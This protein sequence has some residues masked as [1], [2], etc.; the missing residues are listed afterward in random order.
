[1]ITSQSVSHAPSKAGLRPAWLDESIFPFRSRFIEISGTKIHYI[2]EG[3][4]QPL[5]LLHAA[6]AS[7]FIYREFIRRLQSKYRCI[8]LDYP[9]FGL[10]EVENGYRVSI[11]VLSQ[12]VEDF[13][14]RL[15]LQHLTMMV[16]DSSGPIGLGAAA[17]DAERYK[18]FIVTD[19]LGFP[20]DEYPVVRL[21][22]KAATGRIFRWLNRK[23]NLLAVLV[24]SVAPV[25]RR[26]S[27][28]EKRAYRQTFATAE[29]RDR[30]LDLLAELLDQ[31]DYLME[32]EEGILNNLS[33]RPALIMYGQFD[34]VRLVGWPNR[35]GALFPYNRQ[36]VVP[37]EG[38]FPHEGSPD[39]MIR[40]ISDWHNS[41]PKG[42][43]G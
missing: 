33:K 28:A 25:R 7:S 32:V 23:L 37:W 43:E 22:L 10:S 17:R 21:G 4:G 16:H 13:V 42:R 6:S 9:G 18:A 5:L 26:L 3:E 41:L 12:V 35:F 1:M 27:C 19:T 31:Q 34:P 11:P 40:E 29:S 20:L 38:H 36:L 2:D 30:V 15:D 14:S 24:S 39:A 8:A